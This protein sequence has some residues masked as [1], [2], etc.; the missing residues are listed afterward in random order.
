MSSP[1]I[2]EELA[3]WFQVQDD[4]CKTHI[5]SAICLVLHCP[6]AR[7]GW[8]HSWKMQSD[9][10]LFGDI[11]SWLTQVLRHYCHNSLII[12]PR[13]EDRNNFTKFVAILSAKIWKVRNHVKF[14]QE[15]W[16]LTQLVKDIY[17]FMQLLRIFTWALTNRAGL[18]RA[19]GLYIK[20]K[21]WRGVCKW[22]GL[23]WGYCPKSWRR[24][25]WGSARVFPC[26]GSLSLLEK[27]WILWLRINS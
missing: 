18:A 6:V 26:S 14:N 22:Y 25:Y 8:S 4:R 15:A 13:K 20:A 19:I 12:I 23:W 7:I 1:P 5:E 9:R 11:L 27:L 24:D 2:K 3:K 16:N 17:R 21:C 10:W